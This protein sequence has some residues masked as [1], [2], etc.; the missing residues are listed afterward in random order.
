MKILIAGAS[1]MIGSVVTPYLE[2]KGHEVIRLVRREPG[3]GE[4]FWDPEADK[5]DAA[6]LEG[7]DGVVHLATMRWPMPWTDEA[8]K[9]IYANRMQTNSLLA[10]SLANCKVKPRVLICSSGMGIYPDSGDIFLTE[11]SPLGTDFLARLQINGEAATVPASTAGIRVVNLRTPAVLSSDV[12]RINTAPLGSGKQ[13]SPWVSR[14][15]LANII[16]FVLEIDTLVGPINPVNPHLVQNGEMAA[17]VSHMLGCGPGQ[18]VPDF[19]LRQML[20]E[21]ADAL[22]LASRR[23]QPTKLLASGYKFNYPGLEDALRHELGLS[24]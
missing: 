19:I 18:A 14:D 7:F 2:S 10:K 1:G 22:I 13:W 12:I 16:L 23:I 3:A 11:D 20:G 5:I 17:T 21:M 6:G 9:L 15:E 24:G 8:K 4:V